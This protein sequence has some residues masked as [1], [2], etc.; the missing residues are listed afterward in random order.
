MDEPIF[1]ILFLFE[2]SIYGKTRIGLLVDAAR[3]RDTIRERRAK[4]WAT[5][6]FYLCSKET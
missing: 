2:V 6:D 5:A 3:A 4:H 1:K